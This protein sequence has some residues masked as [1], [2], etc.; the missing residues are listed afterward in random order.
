MSTFTPYQVDFSVKNAA[1][2][3]GFSKKKVHFKFGFANP[4]A[5]R[6]GL[7]GAQCRGSEH[8]LTFVWSLASGKR[9][10]FVDGKEV[11]YSE[12]GQN[13]WTQ[14]RSWQ[15]AFSLKVGD[16]RYRIHFITQPKQPEIPEIRPFNLLVNGVSYFQFNKIFELGTPRMHV[17]DVDTRGGNRNHGAGRDSPMSPEERR[18]V[19]AAKVESLRELRDHQVRKS[20]SN[21]SGGVEK[22][23]QASM[24]RE[25]NLLS[26]D[27]PP[28]QQI[29]VASRGNTSSLTL[30]SAIES[31]P[32]YA[33][34]GNQI[35]S[36]AVYQDYTQQQPPPYGNY[37]PSPSAGAYAQSPFGSPQVE[38]GQAYGH[39]PQPLSYNMQPPVQAQPPFGQ[40]PTYY[41]ETNLGNTTALAQYQ[42]PSNAP[43]TSPYAVNPSAQMQPPPGPGMYNSLNTPTFESGQPALPSPSAQS[44]ASY[45]SAPSFAQPPRPPQHQQQQLPYQQTFSTPQQYPPPSNGQEFSQPLYTSPTTNPQQYGQS[46][47]FTF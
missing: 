20:G 8:E 9:N 13:G 28:E 1:K 4:E 24:V 6:Q 45:G 25:E 38:Y 3:L 36:P 30:G 16:E 21:D 29:V 22:S 2:T 19:A 34:F 11:H 40:A 32:P 7:M 23:L 46:T 14:D 37:G 26:F 33:S 15:H 35:A 17:R 39:P 41:G 47:Q 5:C 27:D 44:Y 18:A 43:M 31:S 10:L 42:S 12:S